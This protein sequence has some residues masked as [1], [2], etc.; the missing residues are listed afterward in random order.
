MRA[1]NPAYRGPR[2]SR[3]IAVAL[4]MGVV[5]ALEHELPYAH[6]DEPSDYLLQRLAPGA[7][8]L[9]ALKREGGDDGRLLRNGGNDLEGGRLPLRIEVVPVELAGSGRLRPAEREARV[10]PLGVYSCR[11]KVPRRLTCALYALVSVCDYPWLYVLDPP[12]VCS[13]LILCEEAS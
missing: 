3:Y 13:D 6:V 7:F 2:L 10:R 8:G 1:G 4:V 12:P 11:K 9:R 5:A